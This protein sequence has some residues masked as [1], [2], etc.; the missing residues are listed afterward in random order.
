[1]VK[2]YDGAITCLRRAV[3][4]L[5]ARRLDESHNHVVTAAS[6]LRGLSHNL[7]FERGGA[8]A[9]RLQAMYTKNILAILRSVGQPDAAERFNK[10]IKGLNELRDA[11]AL[12]ARLPPDP[13][14]GVR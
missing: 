11:W 13:H 2:L 10:I 7:D 12:V 9:V 8:L 14:Q 5:E 6:I 1:M 4:A 3:A